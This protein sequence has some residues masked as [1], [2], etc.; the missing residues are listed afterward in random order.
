[1]DPEAIWYRRG[2]PLSLLLLPLSWVFCALVRA[3]R[4]AYRRGWL[5]SHRVPVPVIVI[6]NLTVGGT[7][8]TPLAIWLAQLLRRH[9]RRPGIV[10]R[11]Y[12][13]RA[14]KWPQRVSPTSDPFAVGDEALVLARRTAVPVAA[15][16]DR[17][18]AAR[19]LVADGG[20]D[21]IVSDDGLQ[22]YGLQ[23]DLEILVI[24][25]QRDFGNGRCLPA[26]PLREPTARRREADLTVCHGEGCT[27]GVTMWLVPRRLVKLRDPGVT[28]ELASLRRQRVAA[29]AGIGNPGRFFAMLRE[30]GLYLEERP[31]P[32][33]YRFSA[34]DV[35]GWPPGPVIMTEK[36]AVKCEA[37]AG[38]DHWYLPVE[39]AMDAGVE[40]RLLELLDRG[41]PYRERP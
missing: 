35:A 12:G 37:F 39:V 38:P 15:G 22:H 13:G 24:D 19:L 23:R 26:G 5:A 36:D 4:W 30:Q 8:K 11:G 2:H 14:S 41:S 3:R 20:C 29:V 34:E 32:D 28:R 27:E 18:A 1:M 16:P 40:Q 7:G 6:G 31:H 9:G 17:V 21:M 25:G 33:H 10:T